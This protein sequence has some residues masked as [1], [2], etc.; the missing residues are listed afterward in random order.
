M[1]LVYYLEAHE[2]PRILNSTG[3]VHLPP[4]RDPNDYR[5]PESEADEPRIDY[6][7]INPFNLTL[8]VG[9]EWHRFPGHYL[10]PDGVRVDFIKSEFDGMLPGHFK[11]TPRNAG[12]M[13]RIQGTRDIPRGLNDL[14]KEEPSLY[15][16]AEIFSMIPLLISLP[17]VEAHTCD[18]LM[19]SDYPL[20]PV[21]SVHEPRY[22]TDIATWDR[23][24]CEKFLDQ[25]HSSLLTRALWLPGARWQQL[26]EFGEFCLLRNRKNM[27]RKEKTLIVQ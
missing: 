3:H 4:P 11:P 10:V 9:K 5:I 7:L 18:Y 13:A 12:L 24:H 27:E 16:S 2:I 15:V 19:E 17:Q 21:E 8:C 20:H 25:R 14:N 23:V 6:D 26:N 22:A 1:T